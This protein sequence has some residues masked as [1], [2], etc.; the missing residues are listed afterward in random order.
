MA[1][2]RW[3]AHHVGVRPLGAQ[4]Q[5]RQHVGTQID[6]EDLDHG[7]RQ[8]NAEQHEGQIGHDLRDVRSQ[9]VGQELADVLEHRAAFLDGIDDGG[10]M[11]V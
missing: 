3:P 2:P 8:R 4:R 6:R 7:E 11:V 9:D 10:E 5:C 1:P